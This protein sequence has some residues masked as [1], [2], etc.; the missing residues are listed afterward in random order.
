VQADIVIEQ[1]PV[2]QRCPL[3]LS[4]RTIATLLYSSLEVFMIFL[5]KLHDLRAKLP[6]CFIPPTNSNVHAPSA[7]V[8]S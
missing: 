2:E 3:S 5:L 4:G 6:V 8:D 7:L 1:L